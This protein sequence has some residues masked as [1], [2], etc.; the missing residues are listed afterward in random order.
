MKE[1]LWRRVE[2]FVR[3]W[4]NARRLGLTYAG[5]HQFVDNFRFPAFV[6]VAGKRLELAL[7][8]EGGVVADFVECLIEDAY[9]L[10]SLKRQPDTILD[11][12]GNVGLFIVAARHRFPSARLDAYEPN[13]RAHPYLGHQAKM[14][15]CRYFGEALGACDANVAVW[16][17]GDCQHART[18]IREDGNVRQV[19]LD[20]AVARMGGRVD[21]LKLDCEGAEWEL[22]QSPGKVWSAIGDV[23]MEYHCWNGRRVEEMFHLLEKVGLRV[24]RHFFRR[25]DFGIIWA[26]R[27]SGL[28]GW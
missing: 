23:R 13:P 4:K 22:L 17:I 25:E 1:R 8:E 19:T 7:P 28:G 21:L 18:L 14:L 3:R 20:A 15:G 9:G 10:G 5:G 26:S 12:G 16:D 27:R 24:E 6:T 11:V 2:R